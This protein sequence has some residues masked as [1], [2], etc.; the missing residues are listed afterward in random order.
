ML[1]CTCLCHQVRPFI[2]ESSGTVVLMKPDRL[3]QPLMLPL[4]KVQEVVLRWSHWS[5]LIEPVHCCSLPWSIT[6]CTLGI[7]RLTVF[8]PF[9]Y[10]ICLKLV[11]RLGKHLHSFVRPCKQRYIYMVWFHHVN[12][13]KM[14]DLIY[15]SLAI[16]SRI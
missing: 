14:I 1:L 15:T 5:F 7:S 3:I 6:T 10:N 9:R 11:R 12:R 16:L 8:F 13:G 2:P 4:P